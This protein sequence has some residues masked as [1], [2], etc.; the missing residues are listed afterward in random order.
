MNKIVLYCKSYR[1]DVNR[2]KVLF[3]SIQKYNR[4]NIPFYISCPNN[5]IGIFKQALGSSGYTI[6]SDESI[7]GQSGVEDWTSQQIVKSSLWKID[8]CENYLVLDSDSYF[9]RPFYV[10]DFIAPNGEPYVVM[11]EQKEL[12]NW[13]CNKAHLLGFD[14]SISFGECRQKVMDVFGR[15][16][17]YYD[18]GPSPVIW[19][20]NIWKQFKDNYLVP[21]KLT[22]SDVIRIV[23]SEFSWYGEWLMTYEKHM[24]PIEPLFKVFH[25]GAQY[26]EL[27]YQGYTEQNLST[28]YMGIVMQSNASIPLKY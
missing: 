24:L 1:G 13:T 2:I 28:I 8:V 16:G 18:F 6:I 7:C 17:R 26:H 4:D 20:C 14:P 25:Y 19:N 23:P 22:M 11:H 12:F 21:N 5:D 27:K 10:K 3:E 9:I 15:V